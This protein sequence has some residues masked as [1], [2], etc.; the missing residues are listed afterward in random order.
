MSEAQGGRRRSPSRGRRRAPLGVGGK[1]AAGSRIAVGGP[2]GISRLLQR[3]RGGDERQGLGELADLEGVLDC[4]GAGADHEVQVPRLR[5]VGELE[6]DMDAARVDEA[7]P[8]EIG[9]RDTRDGARAPS[10]PR[11]GSPPAQRGRTRPQARSS[12][13]SLADS[14]R[15]SGRL[16]WAVAIGHTRTRARSPRRGF[17]VVVEAAPRP[18]PNRRLPLLPYA[19]RRTRNSPNRRLHPTT[20][21]GLGG[22]MRSCAYRHVCVSPHENPGASLDGPLRAEVS[23]GTRIRSTQR[24]AKPLPRPRST[25]PSKLN[26][27]PDDLTAYFP[28]R[29]ALNPTRESWHKAVARAAAVVHL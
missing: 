3:R 21:E 28:N 17:L 26:T 29:S 2:Y 15:R 9:A 5:T 19:V 8:A 25:R 16:L 6:D 10:R 7:Q 12:W 23:S 11:P 24:R 20:A 18:Y 4:R 1:R 14:R 13:S 22:A 27:Q